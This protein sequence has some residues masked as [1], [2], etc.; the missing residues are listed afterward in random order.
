MISLINIIYFLLFVN[1]IS[2]ESNNNECKF[3]C[4]NKN[5]KPLLNK[6]YIFTSNGCGAHGIKINVNNDIEECCDL[7]DACYSICGIS[8]DFCEQ[9]FDKCLKQKCRNFNNNNNNNNNRHGIKNEQ[10]CLETI[11]LLTMGSSMFGCQSFVSSQN[12][13]C[14]CSD[15]TNNK[16]FYDIIDSLYYFVN[17]NSD[18]KI[19]KKNL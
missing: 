6:E 19:V 3:T 12:E 9:Q 1:L 4:P 8:R 7:H 18:N 5:H 14:I 17:K 15:H 11:N 16:M 10:N 13:S 2:C